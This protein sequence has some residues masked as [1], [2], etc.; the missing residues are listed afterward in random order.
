[1]QLLE[2]SS[3]IVT[4]K[5]IFASAR[6]RYALG[7]LPNRHVF[8]ALEH[9]VFQHMCD[10]GN[11]NIFVHTAGAIPY[12]LDYN[13]GTVVFLDYDLKTIAESLLK[14]LRLCLNSE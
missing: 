6:S 11:A 12:L 1:M 4:G 8:G 10:T 14:H 7:K 3:V 2:I 13:W 5:G 9:H